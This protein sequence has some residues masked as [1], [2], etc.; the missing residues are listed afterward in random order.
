M[1][2]ALSRGRRLFARLRGVMARAAPALDV[3]RV[4]L[5]VLKRCCIDCGACGRVLWALR[6]FMNGKGMRKCL[7]PPS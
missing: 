1:L 4:W 5:D 6:N 3:V 2:T 7:P